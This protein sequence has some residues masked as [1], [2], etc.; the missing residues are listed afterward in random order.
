MAQ[1]QVGAAPRKSLLIDRPAGFDAMASITTGVARRMG[2]YEYRAQYSILG[3]SKLLLL[4][5][6]DPNNSR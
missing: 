3:R 2:E 4:V 6:E 5:L 1:L